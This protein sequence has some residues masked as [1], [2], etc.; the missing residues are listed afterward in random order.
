MTVRVAAV[1]DC[2]VLL[3]RAA[4]LDLVAE[5]TDKAVAEGA[6]LVVFPEAF[7]PGPPVWI[8]ALPVWEDAEWH[9]C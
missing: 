2:P 1:Q 8:D 6:Q 5:L 7:V 9:G 3:D 4:T